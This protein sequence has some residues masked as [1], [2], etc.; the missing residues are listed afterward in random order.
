M[1][2]NPRP[3]GLPKGLYGP[4][5]SRD[6]D[7]GGTGNGSPIHPQHLS[8]TVT[9]EVFGN[10]LLFTGVGRGTMVNIGGTTVTLKR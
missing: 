9:L 6:W 10:T 7:N 8:S 1:F 3:S 2:L 4:L 5:V